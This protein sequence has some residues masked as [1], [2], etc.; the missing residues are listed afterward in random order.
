MTNI[1]KHATA[2]KVKI[3][4]EYDE[5]TLII[6]IE[7]NGVGFDPQLALAGKTDQHWGLIMMKERVEA[8][9]GRFAIESH[10][11]SGTRITTEVPL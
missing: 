4:L 2:S 7:D 5:R 8:V 9:G 11:G 1:V 3:C 10:P 6:L